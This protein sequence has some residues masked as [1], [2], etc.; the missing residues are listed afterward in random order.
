M[1]K[2]VNVNDLEWTVNQQGQK[3]ASKRKSFTKAVGGE[4]LGCS[5]YEIPPGKTAFPFHFHTAN[6]E[7]IYILEGSGT[8][9]LGASTLAVREGD[10]I[11]LR[12]NDPES[13]HQVLNTS[14]Q[15]LRYLCFSTMVVPEVMIYPDSKKVAIMAGAAP[16][17]DK[18]QRTLEMSF[19][20]ESVV[21]YYHREEEEA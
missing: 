11:S 3:F 20:L 18:S 2:I 7:A 17:A 15:P 4:K 5:L 6:E 14:D 16:G 13:A 19:P 1:K 9:R 10:Y 21:N 8:L 12:S